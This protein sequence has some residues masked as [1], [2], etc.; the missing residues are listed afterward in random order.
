M[1]YEGEV[2]WKNGLQNLVAHL[3][4]MEV[5]QVRIGPW[6]IF[7]KIVFLLK[8]LIVT[9]GVVNNQKII[10]EFRHLGTFSGPHMIENATNPTSVS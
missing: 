1:W 7:Q 2:L 8:N 9:R 4:F 10:L 6:L 3:S 5:Y